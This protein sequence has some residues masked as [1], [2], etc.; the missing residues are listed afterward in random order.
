MVDKAVVRRKAIGRE[1]SLIGF[2]PSLVPCDESSDKGFATI[3]CLQIF[4]ELADDLFKSEP[5]RLALGNR[6]E[7]RLSHHS[8][9][10]AN[11][12]D[13]SALGRILDR[14]REHQEA[15]FLLRILFVLL[16]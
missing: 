12:S 8:G 13:G 4:W 9:A 2:P 14:I 11:L 3:R 10:V 16:R 15:G 7:E 6:S 1:Q 5:P